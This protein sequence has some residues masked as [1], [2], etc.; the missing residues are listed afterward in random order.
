[1][2]C[3]HIEFLDLSEI[4][5]QYSAIIRK[6]QTGRLKWPVNLAGV[7][8]EALQFR[9]LA[10]NREALTK[11]KQTKQKSKEGECEQVVYW[12]EFN[13]NKCKERGDHEGRF[14]NTKCL[15]RHICWVC[16]KEGKLQ[17]RHSEKSDSC[18]L[19]Q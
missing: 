4:K 12:N 10:L 5:D 18:P 2:L 13:Q 17:E 8:H 6:I 7:V 1:M 14:N 11:S 19:K 9:T 3:Y 15:K 16:Y